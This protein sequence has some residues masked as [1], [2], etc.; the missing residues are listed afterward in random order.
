MNLLKIGIQKTGRISQDSIL[1]LRNVGLDFDIDTSRQLFARVRNF[2]AEILFFRSKDIPLYVEEGLC[3]LGIV[4]MDVVNEGNDTIKILKKLDFGQCRI[5]LA[6]PKDSTIAKVADL[7]NKTI[8]TSFPNILNDFLKKEKIKAEII[9]MNGSV[10]IAPALEISDAIFDIVSS[11]TTLQSNGLRE[12]YKVFNSEV[13]L[14]Q[15]QSITNKE[16]IKNI[17]H[18]IVRI[19]SILVGNKMKY[20]MMNA[21]VNKLEEIKQKLP[22]LKS[23]TVLPLADSK[24]CAIHSTVPKKDMWQ[25][26]EQ[27]K[28]AGAFGILVSSVDNIII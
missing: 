2:N 23:P 4:G 13:V 18:L 7:N 5:S 15:N 17:N 26:I 19:E 25:V 22:S 28:E 8:A 20:I 16:K 12:F 10:E 9:K 1:L 14:I 11:G 3:D 27:L 24:F 6:I 21:P